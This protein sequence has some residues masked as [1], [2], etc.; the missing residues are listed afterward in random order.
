MAVDQAGKDE[1]ARE[2]DHSDLSVVR[3]RVP[4]LNA[5]HLPTPQGQGHALERSI[6][7]HGQEFPAADPGP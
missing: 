7:R 4:G 5:C 6:A 2:I 1:A 3:V